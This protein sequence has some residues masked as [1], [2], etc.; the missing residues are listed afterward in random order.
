[1]SH[2]ASSGNR[3]EPPWSQD[4]TAEPPNPTLPMSAQPVSGQPAQSES[5]SGQPAE[6]NVDSAGQPAY[7]Y[8]DA[9]DQAP[10]AYGAPAGQPAYG[11]PAGYPPSYYAHPLPPSSTNGLAVASMVVSI[12]AFTGLCAWGFGGFLGIVGAVLGHIS[13]RQLRDREREGNPESGSGMA[14]AGV[15]LG[16]ISTALAVLI[17]AGFIA[18]IILAES[19][20]S[21]STF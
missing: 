9:A 19:V 20:E 10:P 15:V 7:A 11:A 18:V 8:G 21:T 17:V 2:P 4:P 12:T 1:M 13:R 5:V 6:S 16:W 14:L 3:G